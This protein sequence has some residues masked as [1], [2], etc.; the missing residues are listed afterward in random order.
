MNRL[1]FYLFRQLATAFVFAGVSVTFVILFTQSFRMLSLVIDNSSTMMIFFKLLALSVPTFLPLV[2]PLGLGAA[3]VFVYHKLAIDSELVVMRAAGIS[4]LRQGKPA[5]VLAGSVLIIGYA[6]TLWITPLANL[7]LVETQYQVKDSYAVFMSRPGN[8]N[9]ITEGLTF[10]A[11]KRSPQGALEGILIHDVRKPDNPVTIMAD[12]GQVGDNSE[13]PQIVIFNGRRQ[14]MDVKTGH[15]SELSFDQYVL[16]LTA[17]R[18]STTHRLPD[19]REQTVTEL[20]NPSPEMLRAR[21]TREH[22]LAELNQRLATPLLAF[23]Y[24]AI[25]LAAILGGEFNRRGMGRRLLIAAAAIILVQAMFMSVNN[26][27][28]RNLWL[29]FTLHLTALLPAL[30]GFI[31]LNTDYW[32][33]RA[34]ILKRT[35]AA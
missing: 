7:K 14:E 10:Y 3:V 32:R 25:G 24:T 6:L 9:D 22:L 1:G 4:P 2:M 15:L 20:L 23:A 18:S 28:P 12:S 29:A 33:R 30:V 5:F 8:F 26:L 17:L 21:T 35:T 27:V 19:P 16:D 11:H 31:F 34:V 13:Q